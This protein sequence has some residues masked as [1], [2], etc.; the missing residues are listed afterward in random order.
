MVV[1]DQGQKGV[2][3]YP[4]LLAVSGDRLLYL[5]DQATGRKYELTSEAEIRQ[6]VENSG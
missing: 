2:G 4:W 3:G 5:T 6:V 1:I